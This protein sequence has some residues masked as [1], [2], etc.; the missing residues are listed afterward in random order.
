MLVLPLLSFALLWVIFHQQTPRDLPIAVCDLDRSALSRQLIRMIDAS[1][2]MQ[3]ADRVQQPRDGRELILTGSAYAL[4]LLPKDLERDAKRGKAPPVVAYYNA[5]WLLPGSVV[6][7]DLGLVVGTLSAGIDMRRREAQGEMPTAALA[8]LEPIRIEAHPLF[9]PQLSYTY[10]LVSALLPTMLQI[11]VLV[12]MVHSL[13]IELKERTAAA[14]LERAGMC[15]SRAVVGKFLPYSVVFVA[16]GLFM[17]GLLFESIGVPLRGSLAVLIL[18]TVLFVLA[19]Q[20]VGLLI[21]A[22]FANLRLGTSAAAFYSA[23]AFAFVGITFP[24]MAMPLPGQLWGS[25]LPLTHY[26]RIMVDQTIRGA[27]ITAS[28]PELGAL[29]AF[30]IVLPAVSLRRMRKVARDPAYWGRQ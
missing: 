1:P 11:F 30:L 7:R 26:L 14:W 22:W 17:N 4:V 13:G 12:T 19:Q 25:I 29:L 9:N 20:M 27:P 28:A 15:V 18:G 5:Q 2:S 24:T 8:H 10:Y 21:V 6:N 16:I 3:V 23:P